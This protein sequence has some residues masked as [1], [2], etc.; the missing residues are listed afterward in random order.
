MFGDANVEAPAEA[1]TQFQIF[2]VS[3]DELERAAKRPA[4]GREH[5]VLQPMVAVPLL[6]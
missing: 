1:D 6:K 3:D 2:D 5:G 4:E